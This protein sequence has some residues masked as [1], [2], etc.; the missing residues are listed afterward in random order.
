[1]CNKSTDY[2]S[3]NLGGQDKDRSD[4]I[5]ALLFVKFFEDTRL[6]RMNVYYDTEL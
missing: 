1:M 6:L 3:T 5:M 2:K 4:D